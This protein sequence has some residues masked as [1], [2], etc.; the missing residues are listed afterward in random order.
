MIMASIARLAYGVRRWMRQWFQYLWQLPDEQRDLENVFSNFKTL[1][2]MSE[3][4]LTP[5]RIITS[6]ARI[7]LIFS[8]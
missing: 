8:A 2:E 5:H 7:L 4:A 6:P 3:A 1:S